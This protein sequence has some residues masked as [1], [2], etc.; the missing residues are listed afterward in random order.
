MKTMKKETR[1]RKPLP[2]KEKKKALTI[3]VKSKFLN[4]AKKE[5]KEIERIYSTK[6]SHPAF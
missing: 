5:L 4:E 6:Q 3:M 2:E 1:G